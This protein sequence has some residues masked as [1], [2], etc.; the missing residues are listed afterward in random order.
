MLL[1]QPEKHQH[2]AANRARLQYTMAKKSA[3]AGVGERE[4][5]VVTDGAQRAVVAICAGRVGGLHTAK[6]AKDSLDKAGNPSMP[7]FA[8]A[9]A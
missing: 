9:N 3:H 1:L 8:A 4:V 2:M 7:Q 6:A 5:A